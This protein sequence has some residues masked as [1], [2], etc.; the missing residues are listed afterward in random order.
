MRSDALPRQ[1]V[2]EAGCYVSQRRG[3]SRQLS[4]W[5]L[6]NEFKKPEYKKAFHRNAQCEG[7][8]FVLES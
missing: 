4:E 5:A 6:I 7:F 3:R 2:R 1:F 8:C